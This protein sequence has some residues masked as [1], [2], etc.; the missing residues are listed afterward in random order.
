MA[1]QKVRQVFGVNKKLIKNILK[2]PKFYL[3]LFLC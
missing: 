1:L 2:S 3:G